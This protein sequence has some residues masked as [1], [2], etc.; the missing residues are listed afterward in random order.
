MKKLEK[1]L[2]EWSSQDLISTDQVLKIKDYERTLSNK[3]LLVNTFIAI[4]ATVIGIGI[5]SMIAANWVS[6]PDWM[7]LTIN[8]VLLIGCGFGVYRSY[9][10]KKLVVFEGGI[11]FFSFLC[12]ASIGIISQVYHTGGRIEH[13]LLFWCVITLPL[14]TMSKRFYLPFLWSSVFISI[15]VMNSSITLLFESGRFIQLISIIPLICGAIASILDMTKLNEYFLKS[16]RYL[17]FSL[18]LSAVICADFYGYLE[19]SSIQLQ[20]LVPSIV[21]AIVFIII[22]IIR[23]D[24]N[25]KRKIVFS[26]MLVFYILVFALLGIDSR[27]DYWGAFIDIPFLFL[28]SIYFLS[29]DYKRMFSFLTVVVGVRFLIV[30]FQ[31]FG[32]LASTGIGL[33]ISGV[34]ILASLKLWIKFNPMFEKWTNKLMETE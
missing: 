8:F 2:K 7:K 23:T 11:V 30:Y 1:K 17:A 31:A 32:G 3:N 28:A 14:V 9:I 18:G 24:V 26:L 27:E 16:F 4:A 22:F 6:F 13:A 34:L 33:I 5:I 20:S 19:S 12:L 21:L 25:I 15:L 10:A 29:I